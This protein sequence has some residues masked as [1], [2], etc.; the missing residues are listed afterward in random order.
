MI[1]KLAEHVTP[2]QLKSHGFT[3]AVSERRLSQTKYEY[4][5]N[6][7]TYYGVVAIDET[8]KIVSLQYAFCTPETDIS[9]S[10]ADVHFKDLIS[11]GIVYSIK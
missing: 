2:K 3:K 10:S 9:D 11:N 7:K 4:R 1:Y 5:R 8:S 6:M